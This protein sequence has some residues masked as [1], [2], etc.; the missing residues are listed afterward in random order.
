MKK[1]IC[2]T[3]ALLVAALPAFSRER[4]KS[5][6]LN[7]ASEVLIKNGDGSKRSVIRNK[8]LKILDEKPSYTVVGFDGGSYAIVSNDDILPEILGYS[9]SSYTSDSENPGFAWW[10]RSIDDACTQIVKRGV[11]PA[12]ISPDASVSPEVPHLLS[13]VWGQMEPFNDLCPLEYDASGRLVGRSVVGCVATSASQVMRYHQHPVQGEGVHVDM[14]TVDANGKVVPLKVDFK[15]YVFDYSKMKDSY[16]AG[17]YTREEGEA[18]ANLCYPVGVSF[19]MIYGTEASGTFSDS[20]VYS[21]NKYLKYPDATLMERFNY[22]EDVWMKTIFK[23]LSERR[24]VLYSG[25][26]DFLTVGGGGHAFVFDGYDSDGLVH[27]NWGWY[28]RNDGYYE[29]ALLN[30]RIHSFRNQQDMIIGVAPPATGSHTGETLALV[31]PVSASDLSEAVRK[32]KEEGYTGL[33]LSLA[34][35]PDNRLP[36]RA[37]YSS[38]F[39]TIILPF[40]L[41]SIGDGVFGHCPRL[42]EVVFP[43]FSA[44]Q[45]FVVEDNIIY[46]KD[47][48]EV[49]GVLPYYHNNDLV[50][51]DYN[52]LLKFRKEVR[53]IHPYAAD[54]CFRISGVEIPENVEKIGYHAFANATKL[55]VVTVSAT[56]PPSLAMWAFPNLDAAYTGL[57]VR[58]GYG[59]TYYRTGEWGAFYA[60]DNVFEYGTT[61]R[62]RNVVRESG[63]PNPEL[64]YQVFGEYVT[65]EP[66]LSCDA[67]EASPVGDYVIRVGMGSLQG[68]D[69]L[70]NDGILRVVE[71]A[72]VDMVEGSDGEPLDI[73]TLDGKTVARGANSLEGLVPGLY[74]VNGKKIIIE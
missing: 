55:K 8:T 16:S 19:G 46:S 59:D 66:E 60:F 32:S 37:F 1:F 35:L 23:E 69:I 5:E 73:Y 70:L 27:V 10:C 50:I 44:D 18:V 30:P 24:P 26:D 13:D 21:L 52:S 62:A 72:D 51:T 11:A 15:D 53:E 39:R 7:C 20:A 22:K 41:V 48:T 43:P 12:R 74:I 71:S 63:K 4:S 36:D 57:Y 68:D 64:S 42:S 38:Y 56:V 9:A 14:Q 28:G 25:A 2:L 3:S 47:F 67:T 33:D 17:T 34:L 58:A 49:I 65:G 40:T 29:V 31:G 45:E 61:V 54:G 6:I